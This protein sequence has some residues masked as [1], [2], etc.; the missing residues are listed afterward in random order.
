MVSC[1]A[2]YIIWYEA[3]VTNMISC[4]WPDSTHN[5]PARTG[6]IRLVTPPSTSSARENRYR[7]I[8]ANVPGVG[9]LHPTRRYAAAAWNTRQN[10]GRAS[11]VTRI[12]ALWNRA[13]TPCPPPTPNRTLR[14][15]SFIHF[16]RWP[17]LCGEEKEGRK[18]RQL[19]PVL[20]APWERLGAA[21]RLPATQKT[22]PLCSAPN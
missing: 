9:Q 5:N 4:T 6:W 17:T 12:T 13:R 19:G 8:N 2:D 14:S 1:T 21:L 10:S 15:F 20:T 7:F 18:C 16:L 3:Q 22:S 11:K